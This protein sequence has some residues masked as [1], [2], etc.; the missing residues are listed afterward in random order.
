MTPKDRINALHTA[1]AQTGAIIVPLENGPAPVA[2]LMLAKPTLVGTSLPS[3]RL[4]GTFT[5]VTRNERVAKSER[6]VLWAMADGSSY[7]VGYGYALGPHQ[8]ARAKRLFPDQVV[9][10]T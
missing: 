1:L 7:E 10:L 4:I 6:G 9:S 2:L 5:W 3:K 8:I